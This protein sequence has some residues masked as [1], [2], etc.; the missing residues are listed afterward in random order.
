MASHSL[1]SRHGVRAII[2]RHSES[3]VCSHLDF[4]LWPRRSEFQTG[5]L[6]ARCKGAYLQPSGD[7]LTSVG[8]RLEVDVRSRLL[9]DPSLR[10]VDKPVLVRIR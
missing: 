1:Q 9:A 7:D 2:E 6:R 4:R 10:V 5:D 8:V 3:D